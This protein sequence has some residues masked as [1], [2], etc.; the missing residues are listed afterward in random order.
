MQAGCFIRGGPRKWWWLLAALSFTLEANAASLKSETMVAWD[1]YLQTVNAEVRDRVR[2]Q[3]AFLWALEDADRAA[4][5]RSG[6]IVVAPAPGQNPKKVPGGLIH[7]WVGAMFVPDIRLDDILKVTHDYDHY[8]DVYRPSVV[9]SRTLSHSGS[10]DRFAMLLMN[11]GFLSTTALETEYQ[12]TGVRLDDRRFYSVSRTTR[13]QEIEGYGKPDESRIAE[14]EG[15]GFIWKI[16][17]ITRFEQSDD[18]VYVEFEA[19]VLSRPIPSVVRLVV[20]PI[21]RRVSR[22]SLVSSLQRTAEAARGKFLA[23][24]R[25]E[26]VPA[27]GA[28]RRGIASSP[29]IKGFGFA[30]SH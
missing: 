27:G 28:E 20:D 15:N 6:D 23:A 29:S 1:D 21:V 10:D 5:I 3:G 17:S 22:D 12:A 4:R 30:N 13:V 14:G 16:S 18:G 25:P 24:S 8:K 9:E 7:H 19:I 2:P 26:S 11:K